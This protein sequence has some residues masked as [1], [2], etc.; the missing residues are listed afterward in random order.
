MRARAQLWPWRARA[1]GSLVQEASR[2][3]RREQAGRQRLGR[4]GGNA[5][6]ESERW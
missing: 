3:S 5:R 1:H 6:G 2:A 4:G